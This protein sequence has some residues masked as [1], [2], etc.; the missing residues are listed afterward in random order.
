VWS[1]YAGETET[2]A[3]R[4]KDPEAGYESPMATCVVICPGRERISELGRSIEIGLYLVATDLR[5]RFSNRLILLDFLV[6]WV[7]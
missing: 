5:K 4:L 3:C 7:S 2:L 6:A 1:N